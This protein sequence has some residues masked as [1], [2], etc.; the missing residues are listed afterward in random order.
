VSNSKSAGV[1]ALIADDVLQGILKISSDAIIVADDTARILMVNAGAEAMF[2]YGADELVGQPIERLM[3]PRFRAGHSAHVRRFAAGAGESRVMSERQE[4]LGLRKNGEEFP[5]EASLSKRRTADGLVFTTIIRD[6]TEQKRQLQA[7]AESEANYRVLA[8]NATDIIL[9]FGPDGLI[10]YVSPACRS[11]GLEPEA[12]IGQPITRFLAPEQRDHLP[13]ILAALFGGAHIDRSQR[14]LY[15]L[16]DTC[17]RGVWFESNPR[18]V[19]DEAGAVAEVVT[20]LRDVTRNLAV[21]TALAESEARYRMLAD[22]A[23]DLIVRYDK[24]G[25]IEY[26]SPSVR[27]LGYRPEDMVGRNTTEFI[28]PDDLPQAAQNRSFGIGG[29]AEDRLGDIRVRRTDG[30]WVW[31]QGN[32]TPIRDEAGHVVAIMT[33]LRDVSARRAMEEE[34]RRKGA[35]AA[36]AAIAKAE[37]LANMSHEIRTPLTGI[38]G[39]A[40]LLEKLDGL[41]PKARTY[42]SRI[43]TASQALLSVVNDVLDFSKIEAGQVELD[44]QAFDPEAFVAE[45]LD[46]M[47]AQAKNKGLELCMELSSALP[48]AVFADRGRVR[49]VLLNLLS[50][51]VKFTAQGGVTVAVSHEAAD[52]GRLRI[53]VT[54]TGVGVPAERADR[55]FQRF[56]QVDGSISRQYGGTGLGLAISKSLTQLMGGAIGVDSAGAGGS[57]FWFT[58]AA[59]IAGLDL[60]GPVEDGDAWTLGPAHILV[61]DDV[62]MNRELV[63]AMLT[64]FGA[65]FTE[66]ASGAEAVEAALSTAFDLILMDLQMPGMDGLAATRAIRANSELNRDTPILALSANVLPGHLEACREAGMDDHIAKPIDAEELLTK[67]ALWTEPSEG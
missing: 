10:R 62:A 36:A 13:A 21:E 15:K 55:L 38:V 54:D 67:I 43:T 27:Q 45:T 64:P 56:S 52:G 66:A 61:V 40:G 48:A 28:H 3:P 32:P 19:R 4:I 11:L 12:Q 53:A 41:P 18:L 24:K 9:R 51:A 2:G 39:F 37:F 23:T 30:E 42:L 57:T 63:T 58:I 46:L 29:R 8:D 60:A 17:G 31:L 1:P 26:A 16:L 33:S 25:V 35:E 65:R 34:L 44:P 20:T 22:Q 6:I 5:V 7:L 14:R 47:R 49:Q 59:P 50:N